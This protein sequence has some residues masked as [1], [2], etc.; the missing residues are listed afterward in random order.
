MPIATIAATAGP[1]S[2][3][4]ESSRLF[5]TNASAFKPSMN[6]SA[7]AVV[8]SS[9]SPALRRFTGTES[10]HRKS[11]GTDA[12]RDAVAQGADALGRVGEE[13]GQE[14]H[15]AHGGDGESQQGP[16]GESAHGAT[17]AQPDGAPGLARRP[18]RH[19]RDPGAER[20]ERQ[21]GR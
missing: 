1:R 20:R 8:A 11:G 14:I 18:T 21:I 17:L 12:G 10:A 2:V 19:P 7:V 13:C 15:D 16:G 3:R 6:M 9:T 4:H 5:T